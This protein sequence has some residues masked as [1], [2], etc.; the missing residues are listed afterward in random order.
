MYITGL[1]TFTCVAACL[2]LLFGFNVFITS[3][4]ANIRSTLLAKLCVGGIFTLWFKRPLLGA[5][6]IAAP[7]TDGLN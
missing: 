7:P 6:M 1:N 3:Y 2:I 4:T 5:L